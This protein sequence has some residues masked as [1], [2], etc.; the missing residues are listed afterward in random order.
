[1]ARRMYDL[2]NGTEDIK[3]K[4]LLEDNAIS[5]KKDAGENLLIE[6]QT[7]GIILKDVYENV[8]QIGEAGIVFSSIGSQRLLINPQI[9]T[10]KAPITLSN[11]TTALRPALT[12]EGT[13]LYDSTL[14]KVYT[15]QRNCLG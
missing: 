9:V 13:V 11:Y 10:F 12:I 4:I 8:I 5:V 3:V 6:N 1:M 7:E 15:T 14:K 2:D